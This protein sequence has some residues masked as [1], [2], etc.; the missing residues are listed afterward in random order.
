MNQYLARMRKKEAE[1][2][3]KIY[4]LRRV[5]F[6]CIA[7]ILL[8]TIIS[9]ISIKNSMPTVVIEDPE[10][11]E[12]TLFFTDFLTPEPTK[13]PITVLI[14]HTHN[15]ES[16][17]KGTKKYIETDIGRSFDEKYN[18]IAVGEALKKKLERYGFYVEHDKSDNVS[19]GFNYAYDTSLK[20]IK[21]RGKNYDIYIDLHRD[22]YAQTDKNYITDALGK[23]YAFIRLVVA[24]GKNYKEKPNYSLNYKFAEKLNNKM[25][26]ILSGITKEIF[27]KDARLNQHLSG[28]CLLIEIGNEKNDLS[29]VI[30]STDIIAKALDE[31]S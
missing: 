15:D 8:F 1:D 11:T 12:N 20:N 17:Y 28:K 19:D 22:A 31:I 3:R 10:N 14:Y 23:E 18:V 24:N 5:I 2:K 27:I 26:L 13:K 9:A 16:Y 21:N 25:N 29:Q 7:L 6:V 30:N 4:I